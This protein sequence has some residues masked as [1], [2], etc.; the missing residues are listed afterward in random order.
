M[1]IAVGDAVTVRKQ[2]QPLG[3]HRAAGRAVDDRAGCAALIAVLHRLA[4][5]P[6]AEKSLPGRVTFAWVSR[7]E[8]GLEGATELAGRLRPDLVFAIDTFVASDSPLERSYFSGAA[9]GE[10]AVLRAADSSN[11]TPLSLVREVRRQAEV[12]GIPV[13]SGVSR[14]GNDGSV[15]AR[16]GTPDLPLSWPGRYSHS[17]VE[18]ID[19]RD[20]DA[21]A[22]LIL[23]L[24]SD[25]PKIP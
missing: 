1:G 10:G 17:A 24:A 22:D 8:I 3:D 11:L 13:Q 18:V 2:F 16:H 25:P 9:L 21:L 20:H 14:G 7:E 12:A 19:S 23:L 6:A 5:M 4:R 15:F